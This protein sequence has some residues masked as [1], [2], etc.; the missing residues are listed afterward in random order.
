MNVN[1]N[2]NL[3]WT[4]VNHK[5]WNIYIAATNKGL[6]FVGSQ[7]GAKQELLLF[8]EKYFPK[9]EMVNDEVQLEVYKKEIIEFLNGER[10]DFNLNVDFRGTAFQN[11][12]WNALRSINYGETKT[13]SDIAATINKPKSVRAVG[14]AIGANPLLIIIPCHRVIGKNGALSGYRGGLDMKKSLL[15]IE[16]IY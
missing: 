10:I 12:V 5:E 4:I 3:Y 8:K 16:S 9:I 13:Y 15:K 6:C 7:N 1:S 11:D 2:D 14:T